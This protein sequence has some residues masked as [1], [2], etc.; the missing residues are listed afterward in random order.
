MYF[1]T[2]RNLTILNKTFR[3]HFSSFH[4][5]SVFKIRLSVQ[6]WKCQIQLSQIKSN[7][8]DTATHS[9][10]ITVNKAK[11]VMH[12]GS[13]VQRCSRVGEWITFVVNEVDVI[14]AFCHMTKW[15][16][17]DPPLLPPPTVR[18]TEPSRTDR[19]VTEPRCLLQLSHGFWWQ[20]AQQA[21]Q[22]SEPRA[23]RREGGEQRVKG[24]AGGVSGSKQVDRI[25]L[26]VYKKIPDCI[27][28]YYRHYCVEFFRLL[29]AAPRAR[30]WRSCPGPRRRGRRRSGC[31]GSRCGWCTGT[32]SGSSWCREPPPRCGRRRCRRTGSPRAEPRGCRRW[33]TRCGSTS[34]WTRWRWCSWASTLRPGCVFHRALQSH[35]QTPPCKEIEKRLS[36]VHILSF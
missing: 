34:T 17:T 2:R 25:Y 4:S 23:R 28:S 6:T 1:N 13:V 19:A 35:P 29:C 27:R 10:L 16:R 32:R 18:S 31:R 15:E 36:S 26:L 14:W 24:T 5:V 8:V 12:T 7:T 21:C 33:R 30:C 11:C 9:L 20:K 3:K 22:D